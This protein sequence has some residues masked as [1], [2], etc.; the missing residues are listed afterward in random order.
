MTAWFDR[1]PQR[2]F[3]LLSWLVIGVLLILILYDPT[4]D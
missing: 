1:I 4:C 3:R 2:I